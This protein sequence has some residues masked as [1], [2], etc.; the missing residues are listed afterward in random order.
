MHA[1]PHLHFRRLQEAK[2]LRAFTIELAASR[3][4]MAIAGSNGWMG[5]GFARRPETKHCGLLLAK[6]NPRLH[7]CYANNRHTGGVNEKYFSK[8]RSNFGK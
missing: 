1:R 8:F 5:V 3:R 6:K 7:R 2:K 4:T